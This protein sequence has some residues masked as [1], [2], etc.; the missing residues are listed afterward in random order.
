M[1]QLIF[2]PVGPRLLV[3]DIVSELTLEQR[4]AKA[5]LNIVVADNNRPKATQATVVALGDDP[6][7]TESIVFKGVRRPRYMVG[8]IVAFNWH[9]GH[10]QIIEGHEY[11]SIEEAEITGVFRPVEQRQDPFAGSAPGGQTEQCPSPTQIEYQ[12]DTSC[13]EPSPFLPTRTG[14]TTPQEASDRN[15]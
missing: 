14:R 15:Q 13:Q 1:N 5:G 8:D 12:C 7:L 11:R 6:T 3:D 9:A 10:L 4:A 2:S